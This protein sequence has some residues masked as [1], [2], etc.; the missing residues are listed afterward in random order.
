MSGPPAQQLTALTANVF[1]PPR[2]DQGCAEEAAPSPPGLPDCRADFAIPGST[3]LTSS[4]QGAGHTGSWARQAFGPT[5]E[6]LEAF[7]L[8]SRG[9][10]GILS[11]SV[12]NIRQSPA[13]VDTVLA[14]GWDVWSRSCLLCQ[15]YSPRAFYFNLDCSILYCQ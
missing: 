9:T 11:F 8:W 4:G 10:R 14:A 3:I 6:L 2:G 5:R 12:F 1:N 15:P 7:P 13:S